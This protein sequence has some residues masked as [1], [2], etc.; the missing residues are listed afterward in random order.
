VRDSF[1]SDPVQRAP[2]HADQRRRQG[3]RYKGFTTVARGLRSFLRGRPTQR[4]PHYGKSLRRCTTP[5]APA[6]SCEEVSL[7]R[8][9]KGTRVKAPLRHA[10]YLCRRWT[11]PA[12]TASPDC[13]FRPSRTIAATGSRHSG[14]LQRRARWRSLASFTF[15]EL[16]V[17]DELPVIYIPRVRRFVCTKCGSRK[18]QVRSEWPQRK[19]GG[20]SFFSPEFE[21]AIGK[22]ET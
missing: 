15:D 22:A 4:G 2:L 14:L 21:A 1:P 12:P 6:C 7:A 13:L 3:G 10:P 9:P 16:R 18:V 5:E 8:G 20:G 11:K 17:P 19:R